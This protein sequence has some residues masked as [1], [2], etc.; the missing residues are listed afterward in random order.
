[1]T[2]PS[3]ESVAAG[4]ELVLTPPEPVPVIAAEQVST[5]VPVSSDTRR[6]LSERAASYVGSL[7]RLDPRS[8][9]C[10]AEV[11]EIETGGGVV[12]RSSGHWSKRLGVQ[13]VADLACWK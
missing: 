11:G 13:W 10:S 6:E 9:E 4:D 5:M 12:M 2:T 8:P 1:M 7:E 3:Q